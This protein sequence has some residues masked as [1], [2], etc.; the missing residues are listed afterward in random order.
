VTDGLAVVAAWLMFGLLLLALCAVI[1]RG[2]GR[3]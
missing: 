3:Q 1:L 2:G